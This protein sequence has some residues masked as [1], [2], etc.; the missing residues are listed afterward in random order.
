V[1]ALWKIV[2]AANCACVPGRK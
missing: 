1:T 2:E